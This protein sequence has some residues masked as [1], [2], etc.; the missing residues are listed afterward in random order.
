MTSKRTIRQV[1]VALMLL[2][3]FLLQGTWALAGTTG[4]ISGAVKDDS[5]KPVVGADVKV[6]SASQIASTTTDSSGHFV[7]LSL[8]PDTYTVSIEKDQF[9]PISV[10]GIT[11]F[12]DQNQSFAYTMQPALKTIAHVTSTAAG[13]LV[14][15]G[16]TSDVYSVNAATAAKVTGLGGGGSLDQAYSAIATMPG[17]YVPVGQ[18]G[19]YQSVYIRGGDYDQVGYEVDG[20]PVNRSFD[21]YPANTASSLGQQEVQVYTGAAPSNAEGQGLSGFI[22][23]VIKTGTYPG[24]ANSDLGIGSPTFYHK[25]N[26][27]VGGASPDR[28]FSYYAGFGGYDQD[29]RALDNQNGAAY[30]SALGYLTGAQCPAGASGPAS[31][32]SNGVYQGGVNTASPF[33]VLGGFNFYDT[34]MITDRDNVINFHFAIPHHHDGGRDDI[35]LLWQSENLVTYAASEPGDLGVSGPYA[36]FPWANVYSGSLNQ[37]VPATTATGASFAPVNP[38]CFPQAGPGLGCGGQVPANLNDN[39]NNVESIVKLQYQ[40]NFSSD[41]YLRVYGYTVY[42]GWFDYGPNSASLCCTGIPPAYDVYAHSYGLSGTFADQLNPHNLL[43]VQGSY[44]SAN[45]QRVYLV[46]P[47]LGGYPYNVGVLVNGAHPN[48]GVCYTTAGVAATCDNGAASFS[49]EQLACAQNPNAMI[50]GGC[51]GEFGPGPGPGGTYPLPAVTAANCGGGPCEWDTVDT[52]MSGE[53]NTVKPEFGSGSITDEW[54]PSDALHINLGVRLDSYTF[55]PQNTQGGASDFWYASW[56]NSYC[57]NPATPSVAPI[58][59]TTPGAG[60]GAGNLPGAVAGATYVPATISNVSDTQTYTVFQPRVAATYTLNPDNVLRF[61]AGKYDQAP[62]TAFEQYTYY[63]QNTPSGGIFNL[64]NFYTLGFTQPTHPIYPET[65]W[66]YDLSWEHQVKGTDLSWK[67]TP[68]FR[69]TQDQ[70]EEFYLDVQTNFVS[71]LNIGSQTSDGVELQIQKGNFAKNGFSGLFSYTYTNASVKYKATSNGTTPVTSINQ[72]ISSYNA[73]T[74]ACN[75]GSAAGKSQYG[76]SVCAAGVT[77]APCYTT[78][79]APVATAAAC[80]AADIAN[81]YWNAPVQGFFDPSASYVPYSLF[82]A[83]APGAGGY[84]SFIAPSVATLVLNYTHDK[85]SITP[86]VQFSSGNKYGYPI[87][88]LGVDASTCTGALGAVAGDPR[89]PYGG[90][91]SSYDAS[92]CGGAFSIPIPNPQTGNFDSIGAFTAPNR[93][94]LSLQTSYQMSPRIQAVLTLANL[95]D[96][97]FGGSKEPWSSFPGVPQYMICGYGAGYAGVGV[98]PI[99]NNYNPGT[100]VQ[101]FRVPSYY[102]GL[103]TLPFNAYLDFRIRI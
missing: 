22:N 41:A 102:P 101:S 90:S 92:T 53:N 72:A 63:D 5:G 85:W 15:A 11:V 36:T 12:A 97:C 99:G 71:G 76:Q 2:V 78:G 48:S 56:N 38:F 33:Y 91:G 46:T 87:D 39:E 10:A 7:F 9:N 6:S 74:S 54:D 18:M 29:F 100:P 31:C 50:P 70:I 58:E 84:G 24:Y 79:G 26:I 19:W 65:S 13:A 8:A 81:P 64:K 62:N 80:T 20:V 75:G 17:A 77:A 55:V 14:K 49:T 21:N 42:S 27:E 66:N 35:Q 44:V 52:G 82:P 68:F 96:G 37:L 95:Y 4:G 51:A 40:K 59:V 86:A 57:T 61:S 3:A 103:G 69:Q 94:T 88:E 60:C 34:N 45:S 28:L 1:A 73:E 32:Y 23:Q 30:G 47:L 93:V 89:Y 83:G 25:A 43:Q 16:T 98:G 67:L